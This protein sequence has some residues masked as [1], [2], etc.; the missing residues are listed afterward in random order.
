MS[1]T[2]NGKRHMAVFEILGEDVVGMSVD[3][4]VP[5]QDLIAKH[6]IGKWA[7][8]S[9]RSEEDKSCVKSRCRYCYARRLR[10]KY[11]AHLAV[12]LRDRAKTGR[13]TILTPE[14]A[15]FAINGVD[16]ESKT[17]WPETQSFPCE[18]S[19]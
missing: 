9:P 16:D 2:R 5:G 6:Q 14:T 15:P 18:E 4:E 3:E 19:A 7:Q 13:N 8:E 10:R 1:R 11:E 17:C 12:H